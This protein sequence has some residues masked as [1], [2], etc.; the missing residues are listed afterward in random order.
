MQL[1]VLSLLLLFQAAPQDTAKVNT[2]VE[3]A[4]LFLNGAEVQRSASL[5]LKRGTNRIAFTGLSTSLNEETIQ[6]R[7]DGD[8]ILES[9]SK[10]INDQTDGEFGDEISRLKNRK[11]TIEDSIKQKKAALTVLDR[12]QNV[13]LTN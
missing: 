13:L 8:I 3:S 2:S 6:L 10:M 12:K 7:T 4:T 11:R 5:M 1:L 9:I